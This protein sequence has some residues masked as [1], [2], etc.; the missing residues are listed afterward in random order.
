M[1]LPT[2][3][4]STRNPTAPKVS[5]VVPSWHTHGSFGLSNPAPTWIADLATFASSLSRSVAAASEL[6]P[7][8]ALASRMKTLARAKP[9]PLGRHLRFA[10]QTP[11]SPLAFMDI[12]PFAGRSRLFFWPRWSVPYNSVLLSREI[13]GGL[14]DGR[15]RA[16]EHRA[17]GARPRGCP[18]P[19]GRNRLAN[20]SPLAPSPPPVSAAPP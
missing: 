16:P 13:E 4:N 14:N 6:L 19:A 15:F 9:A 7:S 1:N 8:A 11:R 20:A 10:I 2:P 5:L 3:G 12:P 17:G 18:R